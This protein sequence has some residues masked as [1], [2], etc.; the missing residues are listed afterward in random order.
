L[1]QRKVR[2]G[3]LV[4]PIKVLNVLNH[5]V[6]PL[7]LLLSEVNAP[8]GSGDEIVVFNATVF[9][10]QE[11]HVFIGQPNSGIR[12]KGMSDMIVKF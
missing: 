4:W 9:P 5:H 10:E 8:E 3:F 6:E 11:F 2:Y 7:I 1:K 12:Y